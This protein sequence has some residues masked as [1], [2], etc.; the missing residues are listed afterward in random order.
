MRSIIVFTIAILAVTFFC[1]TSDAKPVTGF[2]GVSIK[3][4]EDQNH[5]V[6]PGMK[7]VKLVTYTVTNNSWRTVTL[8]SLRFRVK[9][10]GDSPSRIDEFYLYSN[11][12]L[13]AQTGSSPGIV[14]LAFSR[15][16]E[17]DPGTRVTLAVYADLQKSIA[18]GSKIQTESNSAWFGFTHRHRVFPHGIQYGPV[19]TVKQHGTLFVGQSPDSPESR[20]LPGTAQNVNVMSF[21][22]MAQDEP[23]AIKAIPVYFFRL[24][25]GGPD[26]IQMLRVYSQQTLLA[27]AIPTSTDEWPDNPVP[28]FANGPNIWLNEPLVVSPETPA[29]LQIEVDTQAC[30][31]RLGTLGQSGQG[32]QIQIPG[33]EF[34]AKGVSS[35]C[36][37]NAEGLA[38]SGNFHLFGAV[39]QLLGP[40]VFPTMFPLNLNPGME[41]RHIFIFAL[42][43]LQGKIGVSRVSFQID[44]SPG[45]ILSNFEL[46]AG[47][48]KFGY[49]QLEGNILTIEFE[50]VVEIDTVSDMVFYLRADVYSS[51][52]EQDGWLSVRLRGGEQFPESFPGT[53]EEI[54]S[55]SYFLWT[56]FTWSGPLGSSDP[57]VFDLPQWNNSYQVEN[58]SGGTWP[59]LSSPLV[60]TR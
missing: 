14:Q 29:I 41:N 7:S 36:D 44:S 8:S 4:N 23:I 9:V 15:R 47:S 17:I 46:F 18:D 48:G 13:L 3:V 21:V 22:I 53:V 6:V 55:K 11:T 19:V 20:L 27:Q 30:Q 39:P 42:R 1:P 26:Q 35:Q 50:D 28:L 31:N 24:N 58:M 37:I 49:G 10:D 32:F 60:F 33:E 12:H 57:Q 34:V 45:V 52:A 16:L 56:D 40:E 59:V 38:Y 43:T 54:G 51:P 5:I 25:D 2:S